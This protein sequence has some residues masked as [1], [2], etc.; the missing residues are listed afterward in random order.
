MVSDDCRPLGIATY[1]LNQWCAGAFTDEVG[2]T[3]WART[4]LDRQVV[5]FRTEAGNPVAL[6]D[7]CRHRKA[8]LSRGMPLGN[9]QERKGERVA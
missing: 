7:R 4:L 8:P 9:A 5:L 2:R 6:T 3:L 1:P